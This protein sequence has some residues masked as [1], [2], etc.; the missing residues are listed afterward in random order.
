[1]R[2][3]VFAVRI[4]FTRGGKR[5]SRRK[6]LFWISCLQQS[7]WRLWCLSRG[8]R[9]TASLPEEAL[10]STDESFSAVKSR[11]VVEGEVS[12]TFQLLSFRPNICVLLSLNFT[13]TSYVLVLS[14]SE[15]ICACPEGASVRSHLQKAFL[16]FHLL[17]IHSF[18][19]LLFS[20]SFVTTMS[21]LVGHFSFLGQTRLFPLSLPTHC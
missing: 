5:F 7:R 6:S 18:L 19:R 4:S 10:F 3:A 1:M 8:G 11:L 16:R 12:S 2:S 15:Y 9:F 20:F 21:I 13:V 14:F 17:Y